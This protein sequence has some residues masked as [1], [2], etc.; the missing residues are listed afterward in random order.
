MWPVNNITN[1]SVTISVIEQFV[2]LLPGHTEYMY[3]VC[4]SWTVPFKLKSNNICQV[5]KT[6]LMWK[7]SSSD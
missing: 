7:S 2:I 5:L 4:I 3:N 1:C 6:F